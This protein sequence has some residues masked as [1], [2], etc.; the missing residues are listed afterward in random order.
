MAN[1]VAMLQLDLADPT[2]T[3]RRC[4]E[5]EPSAPASSAA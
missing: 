1:S 2:S 4:A 3:P 5:R